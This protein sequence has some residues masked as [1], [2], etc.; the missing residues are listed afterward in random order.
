MRT[1]D[2][3]VE[4]L[5]D[6]FLNVSFPASRNR[7]VVLRRYIN[8]RWSNTHWFT[9][10]TDLFVVRYKSWHTD[11]KWIWRSIQCFKTR[12]N[13]TRVYAHGDIGSVLFH[14]S[15]ERRTKIRMYWRFTNR[16]S[17]SNVWAPMFVRIVV[18]NCT[19]RRLCTWVCVF[20][21][22]SALHRG[23]KSGSSPF[24]GRANSCVY[25]NDF[26]FTRKLIEQCPNLDWRFW[27]HFSI[28]WI[29][30]VVILKSLEKLLD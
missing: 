4:R 30:L 8:L 19:P 22:V 13:K 20:S 5:T 18:N 12:L 14:R 27:S 15:V 11:A 9:L 29:R 24:G 10:E 25:T 7:A 21:A 3:P 6:P 26:N 16:I 28:I 17:M 23:N 1:K 2:N